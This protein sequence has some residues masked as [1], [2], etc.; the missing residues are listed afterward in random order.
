MSN[1]EL[2]TKQIEAKRARE[3]TVVLH[4]IEAY[5]HGKHGTRRDKLCTECTQLAEYADM[6]ISRCPFMA[7]KTFCSQC[8][9]HCYTPEKLQAINEKALGRIPPRDIPFDE[10][11]RKLQ[12]K[13]KIP[14]RTVLCRLNGIFCFI[15]ERGARRGPQRKKPD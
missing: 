2:T 1:R 14:F 7:T 15:W 12:M 3:K 4:M 9:V 13:Q 11:A 8:H 10:A 5:C 6:R